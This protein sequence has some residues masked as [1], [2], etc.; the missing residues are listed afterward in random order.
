MASEVS[1]RVEHLTKEYRLGTINHGVLYRDL[2]SWWAR[3]RS[4]EDPNAKIVDRPLDRSDATRITGDRFRALEDVSFDVRQGE[5][6]GIIGRN[7]AGKS[8]LLKILSRITAPTKGIA[9]LRGRIA[10]LLEVG[11]GFHPELTGRENIFLNGAILGMRHS[12]I[13]RRLDEII[14][15]AE[16]GQFV[17]TPVK[18]YSSGMYVRLAFSVAAHLDPD[19]LVIDEVLAVGDLAFQK[20][21]LGKMQSAGRAGRTVLF[22][23]HNLTAVGQMCN[24]CILLSGGKIVTEGPPAE[25]VSKYVSLSTDGSL[26]AR[27]YRAAG[28]GYVAKIRKAAILNLAGDVAPVVDLSDDWV[29]HIEYELY[30][31]T[32]GLSVGMQIIAAD[33]NQTIIS[34][35]DPELELTRL[36]E[37]AAGYYRTQVRIPGKLLN[38]GIYTLRVGVSTRFTIFDVIEDISF[39]VQD[40]VGIVQ[41]LGYQR[42]NSVLALQLPWVIERVNAMS[43]ESHGARKV[44]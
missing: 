17:D 30:K 2:Q 11:T 16:I 38:T 9:K 8:T 19:I 14:E 36:Q 37:R 28:K 35:S 32:P 27:E 43:V 1:I 22:V 4:K 34:L 39:E 40:R 3:L 29:V 18:R 5:V 15:F 25:V 24:R 10:S 26:A 31:P 33:G 6:L 42:K 7:G 12:E 41:A 13:T 20:K 44:D 21:C 23:S